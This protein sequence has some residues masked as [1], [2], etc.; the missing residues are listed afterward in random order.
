MISV[1]WW[2]VARLSSNR[3]MQATSRSGAPPSSVSRSAASRGWASPGSTS[4]RTPCARTTAAQCCALDEGT[5]GPWAARPAPSPRPRDACPAAARGAM[6][7]ARNGSRRAASGGSIARGRRPSGEHRGARRTLLR[8]R[9]MAPSP[10]ARRSA[11]PAEARRPRSKRGGQALRDTPIGSESL[12]AMRLWLRGAAARAAARPRERD[13]A[14]PEAELCF[15]VKAIGVEDSAWLL[16]LATPDQITAALDLDA[17]PEL[18]RFPALSAWTGAL[19]STERRAFMRSIEALETSCSRSTCARASRCSRSRTTTTAGR[20]PAARR[21]WRAS[22]TTPRGT[23]AKTS[24][25]SASSCT[26][27]SKRTTGATSG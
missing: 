5:D 26:R 19:A 10:R 27:S 22:S 17:A 4:A 14:D 8:L 24:R 3:P 2:R 11:R 13:P 23:T 12:V 21:R 18:T 20:R 25:P 16:E 7:V 15:T 1:F 6:A 9:P